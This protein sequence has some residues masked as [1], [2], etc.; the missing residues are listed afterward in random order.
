MI[1][2]FKT[3]I[4]LSIC[5]LFA[6]N[7]QAQ[8]YCNTDF[9]STPQSFQIY[10]VNDYGIQNI[11][12][13]TTIENNNFGGLNVYEHNAYGI[14]SIVPSQSIEKNYSG[15]IEIYNHNSYGIKEITPSQVI[16]PTYDNALPTY[17]NYSTNYFKT[18]R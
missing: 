1:K 12:P 2:T 4:A 3:T 16:K 14:K 8:T 9:F 7:S 11:T 15:N 13:S 5:V 17:N 10:D 18:I 6:I